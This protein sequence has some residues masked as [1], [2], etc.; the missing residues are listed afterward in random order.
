MAKKQN[1]KKEA[2]RLENEAF[3]E[4]MRQEPG[5]T[6]LP[7]GVLSKVIATGDPDSP[8]PKAGNVITCHYQGSLIS[9]R[10]FDDTRKDG[11]PAALRVH[12]LIVGFQIALHRMHIGDRWVIYIPAADG[13]GNKS[14]DNIPAN[15]TL[16]FDLE[17]I[18]VH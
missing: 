11:C 4:K 2:Y 16:I 3:L 14:I 12:E 18:S 10:V 15:S 17:L 13:Y 6:E 8:S 7:H 5:I 1:S 9:G